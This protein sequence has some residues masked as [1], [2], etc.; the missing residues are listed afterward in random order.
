MATHTNT[1]YYIGTKIVPPQ[2]SAPVKRGGGCPLVPKQMP[3]ISGFVL[4]TH[5]KPNKQPNKWFMIPPD[6]YFVNN[7]P[8]WLLGDAFHYQLIVPHRQKNKRKKV[9]AMFF[10]LTLPLT[11]LLFDRKIYDLFVLDWLPLME[12]RRNNHNVQNSR[13]RS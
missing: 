8:Q 4:H 10:S 9:S 12:K 3:P 11:S 2:R 6:K 13:Y 1:F 5:N 7:F